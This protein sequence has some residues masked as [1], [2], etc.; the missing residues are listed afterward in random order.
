N[1]AVGGD[2]V[3]LVTG[4]ASGVFADKNVG[5]GKTVTVSGLTLTGAD[6]GNYVLLQPIV[7]ANLT[8]AHLTVTANNQSKTYDGAPFSPFTAT[9]SGFVSGEDS[10]VVSGSAGFSGNAV[11]A[12]SAGS[13]TITPTAG[14]LSAAN[15]DFT[16]FN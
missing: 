11:G 5:T 3:S 13:Y 1:N 7:T 14:T 16:T 8:K 4:G 12:V 6:A 2:N 9:L 15:Y 10:S